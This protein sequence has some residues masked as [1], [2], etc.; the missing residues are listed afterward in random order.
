MKGYVVQ[1]PSMT[2]KHGLI[3]YKL[4]EVNCNIKINTWK[5][6]VKHTFNYMYVNISH[7]FIKLLMF[8]QLI[9]VYIFCIFWL[10]W[11]PFLAGKFTK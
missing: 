5:K 10:P 11:Q 2:F 4:R 7:T 6:V 1:R 9:N 3:V 8:I